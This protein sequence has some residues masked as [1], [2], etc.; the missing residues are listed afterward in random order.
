MRLSLPIGIIRAYWNLQLGDLHTNQCD[1]AALRLTRTAVGGTVNTS[2]VSADTHHRSRAGLRMRN[3][4]IESGRNRLHISILIPGPIAGHHR[5]TFVTVSTISYLHPCW[6]RISIASHSLL[7]S[8]FIRWTVCCKIAVKGLATA[9]ADMGAV[10]YTRLKRSVR[11]RRI[12]PYPQG[13]SLS[14][15]Y[16][17]RPYKEA[18]V[19]NRNLMSGS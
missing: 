8:S 3:Y 2:A 16:S 5:G 14:S 15:P 7:W 17:A 6:R 1:I 9:N 11:Q 18:T 19:G 13:Y 4:Y 12:G 10:T